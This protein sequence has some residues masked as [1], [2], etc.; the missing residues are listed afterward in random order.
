MAA[1][2]GSVYVFV[3]KGTV[4]KQQAK[5]TAND[6]SVGD[7]FGEYVRIDKNTVIVGARGAE[8]AD[9]STQIDSGAAYVFFRRGTRWLQQ[10]KLVAS[11]GVGGDNFGM[12]A[13][14][15]GDTAVVGAWFDAEGMNTQQE[16]AYIF[17]RNRAGVWTQQ[18]KILAPD[19]MAG[20]WF[21]LSCGISGDTVIIGARHDN[22][23]PSTPGVLSIE[24]S[25]LILALKR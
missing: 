3:R 1:H 20:D 15:D 13:D 5:L 2:Q 6:A 23:D 10:A 14:V 8:R 7:I 25:P 21:G 4:W 24:Q 22:H 17:N 12:S 16:S 18:T 19:G 9:P 11:D